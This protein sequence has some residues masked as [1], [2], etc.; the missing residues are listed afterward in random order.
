MQVQTHEI[1][2][3]EGPADAVAFLKSQRARVQITHNAV[4]MTITMRSA[5][6]ADRFA[7]SVE[8]CGGSIEGR[9]PLGRQRGYRFEF[10]MPVAWDAYLGGSHAR[11]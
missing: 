3:L 1:E 2:V 7:R 4:N 5:D 11:S 8:A 9:K 6:L 10:I